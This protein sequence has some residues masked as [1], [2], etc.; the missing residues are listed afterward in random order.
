MAENPLVIL[1]CKKIR[2]RNLHVVSDGLT[3]FITCPLIVPD[4]FSMTFY[5]LIF[6]LCLIS[7][8]QTSL[9]TNFPI[10][11]AVH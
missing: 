10:C 2:I 3:I 11:L 9:Q 4:Y 6:A 8:L 1:L 7:Y 5:I